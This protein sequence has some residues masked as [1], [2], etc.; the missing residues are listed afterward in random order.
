[1]STYESMRRDQPSFGW[2]PLDD[3]HEV[4]WWI[5]DAVG[6]SPMVGVGSH[7]L[8]G[9]G[10]RFNRERFDKPTLIYHRTAPLIP[11]DD[12]SYEG[13]VRLLRPGHWSGLSFEHP[14]GRL[15]KLSLAD[16]PT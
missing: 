14:D 10:I 5:H 6:D 4:W 9:P 11:A 13:L 15:A 3:D 16:L 1:M 2:F 12:R 7:E 8:C